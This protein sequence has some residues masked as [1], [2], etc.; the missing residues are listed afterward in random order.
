[1]A[2]KQSVNKP[3]L[4]VETLSAPKRKSALDNPKYW[5]RSGRSVEERVAFLLKYADN[6]MIAELKTWLLSQSATQQ[7]AESQSNTES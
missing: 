6:Q 2:R 4:E 7:P 1:M 5:I 3:Q